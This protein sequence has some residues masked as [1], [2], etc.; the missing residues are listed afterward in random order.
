MDGTIWLAVLDFA[1]VAMFFILATILK[2]RITFFQKF[3]IPTSIIAGFIGLIVGP[4]LLGWISFDI[5]RLGNMVYHLMAIGFIALSLKE[6]E[7]KK[8][9]E[10]VSS[11]IMIASVYLI[12]GIVGFAKDLGKHIL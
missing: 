5:D 12:Q 9:K 3:I 7:R 4:N 11:G 10:I 1:Y 2:S 6:R 8:I